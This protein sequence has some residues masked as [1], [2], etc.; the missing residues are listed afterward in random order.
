M[1]SADAPAAAAD[2]P[3][4][5][6]ESPPTAAG[7]DAESDRGRAAARQ[8]APTPEK[9]GRAQTLAAGTTHVEARLAVAE[10]SVAERA[11]GELVARAGGDVVSRSDDGSVTVLG[12]AVP[13]DRWDEVR[14]DLERLGELRLDRSAPRAGRL[15]I[16]LRLER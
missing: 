6:A 3:P 11:V 2:A 9:S 7:K 14:R 8:A 5:R 16:V 15:R 12:L 10:R 4:K 13:G 1:P